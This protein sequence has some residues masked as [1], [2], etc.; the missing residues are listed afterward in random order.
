MKEKSTL[1]ELNQA[2]NQTKQLKY[3]YERYERLNKLLDKNIPL[4]KHEFQQY[5]YLDSVMEAYRTLN[6]DLPSIPQLEQ[7]INK[8]EIMRDIK[9]MQMNNA[10]KKNGGKHYGRL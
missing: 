8:L 1:D 6:G 3:M 7:K 4:T 2:I 9:V 5:K 10:Q